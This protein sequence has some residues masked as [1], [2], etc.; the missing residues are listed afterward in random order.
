MSFNQAKDSGPQR[1]K[2][3]EE[4]TV[5]RSQILYRSANRTKVRAGGSRGLSISCASSI[6][7]C[8]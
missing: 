4:T 2:R 3:L 8:P 1:E 7:D 5:I 6:P